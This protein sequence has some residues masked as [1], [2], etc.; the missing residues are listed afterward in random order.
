M[1]ALSKNPPELGTRSTTVVEDRE[2]WSARGINWQ[3]SPPLR[4]EKGVQRNTH[5]LPAPPSRL[6]VV[7]G[8]S[9]RIPP[10]AL[11]LANQFSKYQL[12]TP[13]FPADHHS[14]APQKPCLSL[15]LERNPISPDR[16]Q[17]RRSSWRIRLG[18]RCRLCGRR[19]S[20]GRRRFVGYLAEQRLDRAGEHKG[21]KHAAQRQARD[22]GRGLPVT[23]RHPDAQALTARGTAVGARHVGLGPGL[24]DEDQ[25]LR[26]EVGLG[27]EPGRRRFRTS[28]RSCSLAC[29]VFFCA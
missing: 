12:V 11:R 25:P 8:K 20:R 13:S 24:V 14:R 27:V 29:A 6:L 7:A 22:D 1:R 17:L 19:H 2:R 5:T 23:V 28:G 9:R 26:L 16:S 3:T 18:G 21:G 4:Q 10:N 15:A